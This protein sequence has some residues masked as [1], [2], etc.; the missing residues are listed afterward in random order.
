MF[1]RPMRTAKGEKP[2]LKVDFVKNIVALEKET[3][4]SQG[5]AKIVVSYAGL[6]LSFE[7]AVANEDSPVTCHKY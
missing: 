5:N 7:A 6:S 3:L 1:L 2:F 4:H